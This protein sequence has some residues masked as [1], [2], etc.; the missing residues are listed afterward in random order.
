MQALTI[1]YGKATPARAR[2]KHQCNL[3][4]FAFKYPG[5]HTF[6]QKCRSTVKAVS[7]LQSRGHLIVS[8]DQFKFNP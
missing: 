3:L 8:G 4:G 2:G 1:F 5:W 6:D 7:A